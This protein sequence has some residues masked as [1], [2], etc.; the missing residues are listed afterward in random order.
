M[1]APE[2]LHAILDMYGA[3]KEDG[4]LRGRII[5]MGRELQYHKDLYDDTKARLEQEESTIWNSLTQLERDAR[6]RWAARN[7]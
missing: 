1:P 2:N 6:I 5:W 7:A 3:P 4:T